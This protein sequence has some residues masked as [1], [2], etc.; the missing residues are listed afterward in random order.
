VHRVRALV[1]AAAMCLAVAACDSLTPPP[2]G[3]ATAIATATATA[4]AAY[5]PVIDPATFTTA[6]T[7]RYFPLRPGMRWVYR[8]TTE[9]GVERTVVEV[10]SQTRQVMG[11]TTLVVRDTVTRGGGLVED[12]FDW[13][14][15][16]RDGAVW[17]FGEQT[18]EYE[19]GKVASTKGSWEAGVNGALPGVVM[20]AD[21]KVGERYRQEYLRGEA[22]DMAEVLSRTERLTVPTGSYDDVVMT[23]DFTPLEPDL[24]EQ[25]YYARDVGPILTAHIRGGTEIA[26]LVAF[27]P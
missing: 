21:P 18:K 19:N 25:K 22:E 1:P 27:T 4:G 13:Y 26:E 12:T 14:A 15:Q 10:S 2:G 9:E 24:L 23:K 3:A 11:V 16:S 5:A 8:A 7:N 20:P 6:V 17:Y